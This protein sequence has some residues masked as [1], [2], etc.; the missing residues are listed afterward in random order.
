MTGC[1][2]GNNASQSVSIALPALSNRDRSEIRWLLPASSRRSAD[3]DH[4]QGKTG[5]RAT[6]RYC[7]N[8]ARCDKRKPHQP[9]EVAL[10]ETLTPRDLG[11]GADT[12]R[13]HFFEPR[14]PRARAFSRAGSSFPGTWSLQTVR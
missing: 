10:L 3:T 12:I 8:N 7:I 1:A 2:P 6:R 13:G 11:A 5:R 4:L 9:R 14:R